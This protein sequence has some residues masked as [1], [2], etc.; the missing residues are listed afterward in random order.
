MN[1]PWMQ[2]YVKM[3]E[4][5]GLVLGPDYEVALHSLEDPER[6]IIAIANGHV[7]G[8]TIGAPIT[9]VALQ[10]IV[11]HSHET[12]DFRL[13]YTGITGDNRVLRSSTFFIKDEA[14]A[15]VGLLCINFDDSRYRELSDRILKLRHPDIF[16]DNNFVYNETISA[17]ESKPSLKE[18][19]NFHS[20]LP[21][22]TEDVLARSLERLDVA[23]NRLSRQE[24]FALV[25]E[26]EATGFFLVKGAVKQIAE[27]LGCSQTTIY[28]YLNRI[29]EM[30]D[31]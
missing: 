1:A 16:V 6:S 14:G 7:S 19:E 24:K 27:R 8:R 9:S 31:V 15:L 12:E 4:F 20:S 30:S 5:L 13:N 21:G 17:V 18:A 10:A 2:P 22:L 23:P 25:R 26:L 3:T 29:A 28:R 11:N